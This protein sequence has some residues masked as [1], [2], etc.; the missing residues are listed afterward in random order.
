LDVV[1]AGVVVAE[2]GSA[3]VVIDP[4]PDAGILVDWSGSAAIRPAKKRMWGA[5]DGG[6]VGIAAG[7][8]IALN[9]GIDCFVRRQ[10][11]G[12]SSRPHLYA[13]LGSRVISCQIAEMIAHKRAGDCFAIERSC[14]FSMII[15]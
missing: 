8:L 1:A 6:V 5:A 11:K 9:C 13:P 10:S 4:V 14:E 15:R 2:D 12:F 7:C 3:V